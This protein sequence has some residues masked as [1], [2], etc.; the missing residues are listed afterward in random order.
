MIATIS[1]SDMTKIEQIQHAIQEANF[2]RS[3]LTPEA[4]AVPGF[5]SLKIRHLMNNLGAISTNYLDCGTHK[6]STYCSTVFKNDNVQY[7]TAIDSFVEFNEGS[8]MQE[9][10]N[11]AGKLKPGV[12]QMQLV[13]KDWMSVGTESI[14]NDIDLYLYDANHSFESQRDA[15]THF[16][17]SMANE[18]IMCID[19]FS[20]WDFVKNGTEEGLRN[21]KII[22]PS[23]EILFRQEL[24]NGIEG[25][26]HGWHNGVGLFLL[27][28]FCPT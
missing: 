22:L 12:T 1:P 24:F 23:F 3:K 11:N 13:M 9:F 25:D 8:P 19:D 4:L 15:I 27:K 20:V 14:P 17:P 10:L 26:N 6:G 2:F 21:A 16:L 18:F 28:Q 7:A 5:T